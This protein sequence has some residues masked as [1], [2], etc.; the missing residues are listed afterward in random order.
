MRRA[1]TLYTAAE[2]E[3]ASTSRLPYRVPPPELPA[4]S[5]SPP[6]P[7]NESTM[8]AHS[9]AVLRSRS[10]NTFRMLTKMGMAAMRIAASLALV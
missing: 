1:S 8:P 7:P 6:T 4:S 2:S 10:V 5:I 9:V 3:A